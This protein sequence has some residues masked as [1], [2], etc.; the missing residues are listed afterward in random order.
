MQMVR[1]TTAMPRPVALACYAVLRYSWTSPVLP[2]T[3]QQPARAQQR[4]PVICSRKGLCLS[5]PCA[6]CPVPSGRTP[7][8][9]QKARYLGSAQR[10]Q[11]AQRRKGCGGPGGPGG[12]PES[13]QESGQESGVTMASLADAGCLAAGTGAGAEC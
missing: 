6:L 12:R 5:V 1:R 8:R 11:R 2:G 10:A 13:G 3:A 7:A 4:S 9:L